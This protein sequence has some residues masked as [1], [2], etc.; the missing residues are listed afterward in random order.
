MRP[1]LLGAAMA[2]LVLATGVAQAAEYR[3]DPSHSFV[4]FKIQH[5]GY[6]WMWGG[7]NDVEGEFSYDSANPES[8][9]IHII[10]QT[11][12]IDTNHAERDK[13]L[14]SDDFLHVKRYPTA[15][16]T[17]TKFTPS[18]TGGTLE[19]ELTLHGVTRSIAIEVEKIGEGPDPWGGYR[20]GFLGRT[21]ISRGDF[22]MSYNL[23][24]KSESMD[25][26]LG[27]E[28]IRK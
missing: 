3:L 8:A 26:E 17:S 5:L 18:S 11:A 6:S 9:R 22:G 10:I 19:G 13:H 20:V 15:T 28:G 1:N 4:R 14:R 24:P 2:A 12:S 7:F 23:G 21:S 16:F 25:F 27:I